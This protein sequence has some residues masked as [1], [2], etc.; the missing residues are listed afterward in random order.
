[1]EI[2]RKKNKTKKINKVKE[3]IILVYRCKLESAP[4]TA[5]AGSNII[6]F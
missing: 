4:K 1:V 3:K 2:E 5:E 6:R